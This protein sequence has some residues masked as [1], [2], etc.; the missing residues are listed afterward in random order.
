MSYKDEKYRVIVDS[1]FSR[2]LDKVNEAIR[3]GW[4]PQGGIAVMKNPKGEY[5]A[6]YHQA[7]IKED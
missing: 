5:D 3:E 6:W 7:L 4:R 1:H 2:F